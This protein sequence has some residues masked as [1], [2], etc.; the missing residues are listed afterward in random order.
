[1]LYSQGDIRQPDP[2][3]YDLHHS[4]ELE[5]IPFWLNLAEKHKGE[6]LELGCGTGRV[7]VRLFQAGYQIYGLDHNAAMLNYLLQNHPVFPSRKLVCADMAA[8]PF[9]QEFVMVLMPCNTYTTLPSSTRLQMLRQVIDHLK[10]GGLFVASLPN[11]W[12]LQHITG[13][14]EPELEK[15]LTHPLDGYPVQ[16]SSSWKRTTNRFTVQWHYDHLFPDGRIERYSVQQFHELNS[17][18]EYLDEMKNS[19]FLSLA[20]YG[21]FDY[22]TYS[23][24]SP[25]LII[26]ARR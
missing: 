17:A 1:M 8:F 2:L 21:N 18:K 26:Q 6:A 20:T 13:E 25:N 15:I 7:L 4:S 23:K 12:Q 10:P 14:G 5:D 22:S 16:I 9:Q 19:G 3:Y 24:H 11:P